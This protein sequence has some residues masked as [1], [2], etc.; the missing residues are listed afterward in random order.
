MSGWTLGPGLPP[1]VHRSRG[2]GRG[3]TRG[4]EAAHRGLDHWPAEGAPPGARPAQPVPL[5]CLYYQQETKLPGTDVPAPSFSGTPS[6]HSP[7][8]AFNPQPPDA[9][10]TLRACKSLCPKCPEHAPSASFSPRP[11]PN[12]KTPGGWESNPR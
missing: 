1:A 2:D 11:D 7:P 10:G 9:R 5:I 3:L 4:A 6:T 12:P 8:R